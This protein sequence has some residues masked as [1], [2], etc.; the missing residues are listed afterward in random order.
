MTRLKHDPRQSYVDEKADTQGLPR[1]FKWIENMAEEEAR[2]T[3][4]SWIA[5]S[6]P[7]QR[8][9]GSKWDVW[10]MMAGRGFGKTRAG[11]EWVKGLVSP[12]RHKGPKSH[13]RIALVAAS[14]H[15]ARSIMVEGESGILS[16]YEEGSPDRPRWEPSLRQLT[17]PNG[18]RAFIY[19]AAEGDALRGPQHHY[20]WADEIGKWERGEVAWMNLRMGLRLGKRPRVLATTTPRHTALIGAL[21]AR[22]EAKA[23]VTISEGKMQDNKSIL[24]AHL[25]EALVDEYGDTALG[26]QELDGEYVRDIE[27]AQLRRASIESTR[28]GALS[29][30]E[31]SLRMQRI[32][33]AVDP[34][35][36]NHG[37]ACGLVAVGLE[38]VELHGAEGAMS[39]RK[40]VR[41]VLLED[42]SIPKPDPLQWADAAMALYK[43]W[44]AGLIVAE[45]NQGGDM[46]VSTLKSAAKDSWGMDHVPIKKIHASTSKGA[47][48]EP[49]TLAYAQGRVV[50]AGRFDALE[51]QMC[52]FTNAGGYAGP[53]KS[54][55]RA[56]AMVWAVT[57]LLLEGRKWQGTGPRIRMV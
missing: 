57:A 30:Q 35:A 24:S 12:A 40:S 45:T 31:A 29:P 10:V 34:P 9:T 22:A 23:A 26:R 50:H 51:D 41:A 56:D 27:G 55:D 52:G 39:G 25:R 20:A 2:I 21:V 49:V 48:A 36:S 43:K 11:A 47:R 3:R 1:A 13:L 8:P 46:V 14:L 7:N 17:W 53:G 5:Q 54:P 6:R 42:A 19:G 15:E 38:E 4:Y 18:A 44:G 32:V 16:L 37:D 28:I 33:V